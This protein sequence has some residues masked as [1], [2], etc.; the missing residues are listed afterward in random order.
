VRIDLAQLA[1][2]L[3]G[4]LALAGPL[5]AQTFVDSPAKLP[6][7][8]G[9]TENVDFADVDGDGDLDAALAEGG[10]P[11]ND[12]NNLWIN[13]GFEPGGTLGFFADRTATQFPAVLDASRDIEF[14][15]LDG[16]GDVDI[17]IANHSSLSNQSARWWINMGG[18]QGGTQGFFQDQT[19]S[20]W[21]GLNVA[22][23]SIAASALLA[24]GFIDWSG[25]GDFG[26]LDNDGD[27][28]LVHSSYGPAFSGSVPTRLF[29][30]DGNGVFRE[31]NPSGFRLSGNSI[32]NGN[33]ALWAQGAQQADTSN[34]T[35]VNADIS[36]SGLDID[37]GDIDGDFDLDLLHG[38]RQEA[39]RMFR[40]RQVESLGVLTAFT[41][42]TH[43]A[44]AP[45]WSAGS[46]HYEQEMGD[47]DN[48]GDLDICGVNWLAPLGF[49]D[50]TL[51]NSGA[52][53]FSA[54]QSLPGSGADDNEADFLD[55]D[56]DG[57]LDIYFANWSG[58]DRLYRND[59]AGA[60]AFSHS[61]VTAA[62]LPPLTRV[63]LDADCADLDNDCDT[64]IVVANNVDQFENYLTN[65]SN[66][67]DTH[68]PRI[69]N[70]E[71]A[72]N[73]A[74]GV[75]PTVVRAQVYDNASYYETWYID[76]QLEFRVAPSGFLAVPM[77]ASQ[78]QIWRGEI[79]GQV[80]GLVEYR[81]RAT[82][83]N[84]NVGVSTTRSFNASGPGGVVYCTA[85]TTTNGC[86]P[87][88]TGSGVALASATSGFTLTVANV[89][90]QRAGL[91]YYGVTGR[92]A[93]PWGVGGTSLTCVKVP[94]QRMSAS[95]SSGGT[96]G[97]C[98]G[99][100]S[101]DWRAFVATHPSATGNPLQ[102]GVQVNAQGW[103]R[104]PPAVKSTN[105]SNALEF[106]V[107][108]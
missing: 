105:L 91:I 102:A 19:S 44:F 96:A 46:G 28:D 82:D 9:S 71:Q 88:I 18:V 63:A 74:T 64:D 14:A 57:D 42:I 26:D 108:P 104:D 95:A 77:H 60:G 70:V 10:D 50:T 52:G 67:A 68:A 98:D 16:D 90:G 37:L 47:C 12:Q 62:E 11:G 27:L 54:N 56:N 73:R 99:V 94:S 34:T 2:T 93:L 31:F 15:D 6:F 78:G 65:Q 41:D 83:R 72:P 40:N 101:E 24:G 5:S 80:A 66:V 79:P 69:P 7:N 8:T 1:L 106:V 38:A 81:V 75:A 100:L 35:G 53:F 97:A 51:A 39:P 86:T 45:G 29:L 4:L 3:P 59:F 20:R 61:N 30:N 87:S 21:S 76:V 107:L 17:Y 49:T 92:A 43:A 22:P 25:D 58:Q 103:F 85:G 48:D 36:S 23:T 84:G 89:E 33:P 55:Y 13:R 32:Q